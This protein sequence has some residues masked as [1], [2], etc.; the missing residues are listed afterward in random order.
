MTT[1]TYDPV[2]NVIIVTDANGCK[3]SYSYD[4]LS[5]RSTMTDAAGDETQYR[6]D[7]G[8]FTGPV[9]GINC[10]QCGATPGSSLGTEQ[11]GPDGAASLHAGV[12]FYKYDALD[13]PIITIRKV[14]WIGAGCTDTIVGTS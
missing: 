11:I 2:G 10:V 5:R 7:T 6:Y 12:S 1:T 4:A 3:T 8:T 14:N 9:R 13:R